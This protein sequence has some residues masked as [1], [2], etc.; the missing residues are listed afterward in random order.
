MQFL[1]K[2]QRINRAVMIL[3]KNWVLLVF[4]AE[5]VLV[6]LY[7]ITALANGGEPFALL[8]V[9]G[10]RTL[11]SYLQA[12]QLFLIGA[13]PFWM[14]VRYRRPDIPPSRK[15]LAFVGL[16]FIYV[17]IDELFKLNFLFGKHRLWQSIYLLV[18][19]AIPFLFYRD[20]KRLY[21]LSPKS[22]QLI[23]L[24]IGIFLLGGFGLE[25]FRAH[26]QEPHWY[27]FF[28][29]WQFYQVDTIRTAFEELGEMLGETIVLKGVVQLFLARQAR[30]KLRTTA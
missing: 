26:I 25:L 7:A 5:V 8:N 28:S 22:M 6:T 18:G 27:R 9:N 24:G 12:I 17:S 2:Q 19:A 13:L 16:F 30:V 4:G 11:P 20:L 15:L 1:T 14:C 3:R 10:L 21:G 23:G 29:R